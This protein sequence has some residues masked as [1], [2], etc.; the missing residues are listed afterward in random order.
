MI[1]NSFHYS[2]IKQPAM[3]IYTHFTDENQAAPP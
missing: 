2:L 3:L 1:D